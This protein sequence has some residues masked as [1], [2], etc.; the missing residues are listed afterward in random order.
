MTIQEQGV[1]VFFGIILTVFIAAI[2]T[3]TQLIPFA[4]FTVGHHTHPIEPALIAMLAGILINQVTSIHHQWQA[5]IRWTQKKILALAIILF[6]IKEIT[7]DLKIIFSWIFFL[8]K[9]KYRYLSLIS[10]EYS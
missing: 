8:L 5:G 7:F 9:S 4:P 1:F 10:S 6:L 3:L 2:S